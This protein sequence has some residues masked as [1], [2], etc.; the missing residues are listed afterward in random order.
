MIDDCLDLDAS[1]LAAVLYARC[2]IRAA[3]LPGF[4]VPHFI[5]GFRLHRGD[6]V[7]I[8][9]PDAPG[10]VEWLRQMERPEARLARAIRGL[11]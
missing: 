9:E 2:R 10:M 1:E 8:A 11:W 4:V 6:L 5:V 3:S 7:G